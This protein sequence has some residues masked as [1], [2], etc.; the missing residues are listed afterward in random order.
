[1][2]YLL[3]ILSLA[4]FL[5]WCRKYHEWTLEDDMRQVVEGSRSFVKPTTTGDER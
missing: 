1:M 5:R 3:T 4:L 2:T